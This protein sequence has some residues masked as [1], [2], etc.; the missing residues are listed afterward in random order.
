MRYTPHVWRILK[1]DFYDLEFTVI[2]ILRDYHSFL[3]TKKEELVSKG[4]HEDFI[5][6][7][8]EERIKS[9][10]RAMLKFQEFYNKA[11]EI[12]E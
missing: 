8:L 7:P 6:H 2:P 5:L 9:V 10:E 1:D 4:I 3:T 11:T 12:H